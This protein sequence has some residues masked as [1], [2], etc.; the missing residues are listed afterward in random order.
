M[1]MFPL[2]W[3]TIQTAKTKCIVVLLERVRYEESK[4]KIP[5]SISKINVFDRCN[6][7]KKMSILKSNPKH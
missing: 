7:N 6:K 1:K 4:V 5:F 3:K 2:F